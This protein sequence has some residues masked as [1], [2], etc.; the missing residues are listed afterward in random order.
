[1]GTAVRLI[2]LEL[3]TAL[4]VLATTHGPPEAPSVTLSVAWVSDTE[5]MGAARVPIVLVPK[6]LVTI[7]VPP[8]TPSVLLVLGP[9]QRIAV[10]RTVPGPTLSVPKVFWAATLLIEVLPRITPP[11]T[12]RLAFGPSRLTMPAEGV[13]EVTPLVVVVPSDWFP[14]YSA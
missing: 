2:T 14:I 11:L 3:P 13:D 5:P 1:M 12:T 10:A 9:P 8:P 7:N 4:R 6:P